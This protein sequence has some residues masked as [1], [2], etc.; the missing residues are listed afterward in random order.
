[1]NYKMNIK[2][3]GKKVKI[4]LIE[5]IK[6]SKIKRLFDISVPK[7]RYQEMKAQMIETLENFHLN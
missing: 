1:M 4:Q 7:D 3:E 6:P 5:Q 2:D